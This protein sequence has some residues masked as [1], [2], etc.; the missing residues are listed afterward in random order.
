MAR[1]HL[2]PK[3]TMPKAP[4]D[5]ARV[6]QEHRKMRQPVK[7]IKTVKAPLWLRQH[8]AE[9]GAGYTPTFDKK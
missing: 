3:G 1:T 2:V 8:R 9:C 6:A 7:S 5:L 4:I